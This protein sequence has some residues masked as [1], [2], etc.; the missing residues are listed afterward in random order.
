MLVFDGTPQKPPD[1]K[2]I[3][4]TSP[5]SS[6]MAGFVCCSETFLVII[7]HNFSMRENERESE[8]IRES[9]RKSQRGSE[10][11][12]ERVKESVR[13]SQRE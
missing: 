9:Q 2:Q 4:V 13:E 12:S 10:R 11:E 3:F 1:M 7:F 6:E 5:A 8:S